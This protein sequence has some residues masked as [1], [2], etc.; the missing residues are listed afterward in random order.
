[1]D[2]IRNKIC[3]AMAFVAYKINSNRKRNVIFPYFSQCNFFQF[4]FT[5]TETDP[6]GMDYTILPGAFF[7]IGKIK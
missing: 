5:N 6:V 2:E 4:S 7:R 3:P 1:M